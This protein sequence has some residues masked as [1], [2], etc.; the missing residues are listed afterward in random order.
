MVSRQK[1]KEP[2]RW[3]TDG[4]HAAAGEGPI[5]ITE[6]T[7][8]QTWRKATPPMELTLS[9]GSLPKHDA[10]S[11]HNNRPGC[12]PPIPATG[13]PGRPEGRHGLGARDGPV[14]SVRPGTAILQPAAGCTTSGRTPKIVASLCT[15]TRYPGG[16]MHTI[17]RYVKSC[18]HGGSSAGKHNTSWAWQ[19]PVIYD[20]LGQRNLHWPASFNDQ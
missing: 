3:T 5:S 17:T 20:G 13:L 8:G 18:V 16:N 6:T 2:P 14:L 4:R 12:A 9:R 11:S 1:V 7:E 10:L 15:W 19:G